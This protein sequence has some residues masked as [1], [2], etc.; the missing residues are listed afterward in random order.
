MPTFHFSQAIAVRYGDIDAQGHVNNAKFITFMEQARFAY[1][2]T[3]GLWQVSQGFE[4]L[5]QIVA[6]V[7]CDYKRQVQLGQVVDVAVRVARVGNK[8]MDFEYRLSVDGEEV[9]LGRTV[10]VAYDFKAHQSIPVPA[11]WRAKLAAFEGL[12]A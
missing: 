9:A 6:S 3:V 8:S 7:S 2:Q 5:G 11:D 12:A 1:A 4:A 10:Q